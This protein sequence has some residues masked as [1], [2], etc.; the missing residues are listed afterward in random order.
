MSLKLETKIFKT[1]ALCSYK[2]QTPNE[3][4]VVEG[5]TIYI[6]DTTM[7]NWVFIASHESIMTFKYGWLPAYIP[8]VENTSIFVTFHHQHIP[9]PSQIKKY[10]E[11]YGEIVYK[12]KKK[13]A[14]YF[15]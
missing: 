12:K 13:H 2:G 3:L 11:H 8:K 9:H 1:T 14:K 10:F 7:K 6:L 4:S 15:T 5:E